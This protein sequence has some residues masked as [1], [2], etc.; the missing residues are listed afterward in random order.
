MRRTMRMT[1]GILAF[2]TATIALAQSPIDYYP[3]KKDTKWVYKVGDNTIE[4]KVAES[5]KDGAKLDTIVNGKTVASE[6]VK[7]EADGIYR[8]KINTA[9]IEPPVKF[10]ELKDNK[11]AAKG[12]KWSVDSKVQQ[13][14]VKGEFSITADKD[15][16]KVPQGE[17]EAVVV[18]G[19]NFEIAGT[20]TAVKYWFAPK[21]GIVKL[22][23]SIGGN[24]AVLEL[25]EFTE[26]K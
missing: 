25:K 2:A 21:I 10:L 9:A 12:T 26:G 11:P 20:K 15:K 19:P 23:Y 4:V 8:T 5:G 16:V 6:M 7:V 22:S 13:Q 24:E 17:H 3:L 14:V 1:F 18:D